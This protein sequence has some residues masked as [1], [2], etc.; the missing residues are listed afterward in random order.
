[1]IMMGD[2]KR[3]IAAIL[4]PHPSEQ[5]EDDG[6]DASHAVAEEL[7]EALHAKDAAGVVSALRALFDEFD[8]QPHAEGP[9]TNED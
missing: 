1:M 7:I 9:H 2:K 6:P 5:K 4:G 8:S 3:A